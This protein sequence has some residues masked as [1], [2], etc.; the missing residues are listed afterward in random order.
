MSE[1]NYGKKDLQIRI[2]IEIV[3]DIKDI[4][5]GIKELQG[6]EKGRISKGRFEE[7]RRLGAFDEVNLYNSP[8]QGIYET[9]ATFPLRTHPILHGN[10]GPNDIAKVRMAEIKTA[11]KLVGGVAPL[12]YRLGQVQPGGAGTAAVPVGGGPSATIA[13][14]NFQFKANRQVGVSVYDPG[15]PPDSQLGNLLSKALGGPAKAQKAIA[16]MRNPL[17][18]LRMLATNPVTAALLAG[19]VAVEVA[20]VI[21]RDLV[22]KGSIF[23]R[24]FKNVIFDRFEAL[25]TRE[26]Q[27]RI[28]VGFGPTAQLITTTTA[29]TTNPRDAYN[30]YEVFNRDQIELA[31]K[32]A[33]RDSSGYGP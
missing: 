33:I 31:E 25:R 11:S 15:D 23:D 2:P 8:S 29:G 20:K 32:F 14:Q 5:K 13:K 12:A 10:G 28:L 22:R 27:M 19:L 6:G 1:S 17:G 16:L 9:G 24:T 7:S 3:P 18:L 30:T 21:I 26:Q 4:Q